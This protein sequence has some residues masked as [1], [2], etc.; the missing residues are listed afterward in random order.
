M[1]LDRWAAIADWDGR[2]EGEGGEG[3][4]GWDDGGCCHWI[5]CG[6]CCHEGGCRGGERVF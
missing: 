5:D 4:V 1:R 3:E 6:G 2:E